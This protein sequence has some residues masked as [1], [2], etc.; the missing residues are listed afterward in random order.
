MKTTVWLWLFY[1]FIIIFKIFI[2]R[3]RERAHVCTNGGG[4][5]RE[6]ER[7]PSRLHAASTELDARL[8]LTNCEIMTLAKIQS[9]RL[10]RLGHRHP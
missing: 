4:A 7:T 9:G 3:E 6:G 5:E 1:D 2:L 8:D 10:N